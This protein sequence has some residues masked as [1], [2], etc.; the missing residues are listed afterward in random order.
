ML[1]RFNEGGGVGLKD[2]GIMAG[3]MPHIKFIP[4][5]TGFTHHG[6]FSSVNRKFSGTGS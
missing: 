4:D 5:E 6:L 3:V 1:V 2:T